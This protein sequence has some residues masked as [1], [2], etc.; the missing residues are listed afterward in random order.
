M[1]RREFITLLGGAAAAWPLAVSAQ[2]L[3]VPVIGFLNGQSPDTYPDRL[4]AFRHGLMEAGYVA[5]ENVAIEYHW[6]ENQSDRLPAMVADLVGHKVNVIVAAGG[7]PAARAA[8]AATTTLPIVFSTGIVAALSTK[9]LPSLPAALVL[10]R[11]VTAEL[12]GGIACVISLGR[13]L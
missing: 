3:A 7:T 5:G 4:N 10:S 12:L 2:Q 6:A 13:S 8:N 9:W 11:L 1:K